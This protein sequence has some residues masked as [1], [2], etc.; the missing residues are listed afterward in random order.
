MIELYSKLYRKLKVGLEIPL[1]KEVV[2]IYD[3][4]PRVNYVSDCMYTNRRKERIQNKHV[5][6]DTETD[7][8]YKIIS[9][10]YIVEIPT[11]KV[12]MINELI[13]KTHLI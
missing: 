10:R 5:F 11:I 9:W 1:W 8:D 13:E 3:E 2:N 4:I 12:N 6:F 7:D